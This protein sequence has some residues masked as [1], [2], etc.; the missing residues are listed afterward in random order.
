MPS[1]MILGFRYR[2]SSLTWALQ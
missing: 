2:G 1:H